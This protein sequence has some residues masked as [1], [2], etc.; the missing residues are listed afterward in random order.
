MEGWTLALTRTGSRSRSR[1]GEATS[2]G[3]NAISPNEKDVYE[4]DCAS[5]IPMKWMMSTCQSV[6]ILCGN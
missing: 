6:A 4:E 1:L 2:R 3:A 5:N